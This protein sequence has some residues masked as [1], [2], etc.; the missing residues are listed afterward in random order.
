M[1]KQIKTIQNIKIRSLV[2]DQ[3]DKRRSRIREGC[4]GTQ[5]SKGIQKGNVKIQQRKTRARVIK[6]KMDWKI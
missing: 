4:I 6:Q 2:L 5:F 3:K 1:S